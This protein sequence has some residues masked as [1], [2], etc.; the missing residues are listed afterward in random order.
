MIVMSLHALPPTNV[1][2]ASYTTPN[3]SCKVRPAGKIRG[4][5]CTQNNEPSKKQLQNVHAR[6]SS[7]HTTFGTVDACVMVILVLVHQSSPVYGV[8]AHSTLSYK[9]L[10]VTAVAH[11]FT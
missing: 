1:L 9:G 7:K 5:D 3:Q 11:W 6:T 8:T 4:L 10:S 2:T